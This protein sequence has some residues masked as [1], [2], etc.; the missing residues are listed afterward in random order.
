MVN[1]TE[2]ET[3]A[4]RARR[5]IEA[6]YDCG[7]L[8]TNLSSVITDIRHLCDAENLDFY[9]IERESR[10]LYAEDVSTQ[11]LATNGGSDHVK[12]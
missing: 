3:N 1:A 9:R 2:N 7:D 5:M 12:F 10:Y 6:E 4:Q 8:E 11:V